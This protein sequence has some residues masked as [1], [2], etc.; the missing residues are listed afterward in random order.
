[1][2]IKKIVPI[3]LIITIGFAYACKKAKP[4]LESENSKNEMNLV[5]E[6][7]DFGRVVS[8]SAPGWASFG[9]T[10]NGGS[11]VVTTVSNLAQLQTALNQNK[12]VINITSSFVITSRVEISN[13]SDMTIYG[14]PGVKIKN[15]S[16]TVSNSGIFRLNG[17]SDIIIRNLK[18]EGPGAYDINGWDNMSLLNCS[19]IW[20]DHCNFE[21]GMDGNLDITNGSDYITVTYCKFTYLKPPIPGGLETNDHRYTNMV[22]NSDNSSVDPGKLRVT[23]ARCWWASGC[24]ERMP[25]VRFGKV[26]VVNCY[27]NCTGNNYCVAAGKQANIR[28]EKCNFNGVDDAL[29]QKSSSYTAYQN[30][31][32]IFNNCTG[33]STGAGTA[34]TPPYTIAI[35]GASAV[36]ANISSGAGATLSGNICGF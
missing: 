17:C 26:H 18:F 15:L 23:Y 8:C 31:G 4:N 29:I 22:G 9:G 3:V 27:Y 20:V 28:I 21:D 1:M 10:C 5:Q 33:N 36:P 30:I 12:K 19:R 16:T 7:E 2:K 11:G 24:R 34:F 6:E 35:L 13:K 32:S 25:R 14:S